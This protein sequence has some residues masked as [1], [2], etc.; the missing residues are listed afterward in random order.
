V[1]T[2]PGQLRPCRADVADIAD[3]LT[4]TYGQHETDVL[5]LLRTSTHTADVIRRY[6]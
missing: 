5:R 2:K 6:R 4:A 3:P 1:L